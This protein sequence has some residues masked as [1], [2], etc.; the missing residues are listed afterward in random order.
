MWRVAAAA[1]AVLLPASAAAQ[2]IEIGGGAAWT[3]GYDAGS[4]NATETSNSSTGAAPTT[5]FTSSS[6][7]PA[8]AG[9]DARV[10]V[11][12][13][14]RISAE[15]LFQF[16]RPNLRT[17]LGSDFENALPDVAVGAFSSYLFG[18]SLVYHFGSG[19][20][21]PFVLGGGGYLRLL[22]EDNVDVA[23]GNEAH[24]G[25]GVKIW[26]GTG[27]SRFGLRVDAQISSRS[28]SPGFED[29][30]RALPSFG[31]GVLYRF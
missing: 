13:G 8:V 27:A 22:D 17:T 30:R 14:D 11:Y 5:L 1:M 24:A 18:G 19:R 10:A 20:I 29:K 9:A 31:A 3:G 21:V 25:G 16:S 28:K 26:L 23:S 15:G 12:F 2:T 6:R 7:V 4:R